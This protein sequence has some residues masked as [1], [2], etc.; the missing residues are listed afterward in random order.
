MAGN[1]SV[2]EDQA[3]LREE[4]RQVREEVHELKQLIV[5]LMDLVRNTPEKFVVLKTWTEAEARSAILDLFKS[6]D[7]PLYFSDIAEQLQMDLEL[8]VNVCSHLTDEG[9]L[10]E[11]HE[12]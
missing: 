2:V 4:M 7:H 8:V 11:P 1:V 6:S 5:Q 3:G 9:L 12:R 10:G